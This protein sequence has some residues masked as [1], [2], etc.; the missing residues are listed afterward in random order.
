MVKDYRNDLYANSYRKAVV[1]QKFRYNNK[2]EEIKMFL[3]N[4]KEIFS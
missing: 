1:K 4:N 3:N 2:L